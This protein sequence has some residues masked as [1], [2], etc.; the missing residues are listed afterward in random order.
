MKEGESLAL[1]NWALAK[2]T[3]RAGKCGL[4]QLLLGPLRA[5]DLGFH[6]NDCKSWQVVE[7]GIP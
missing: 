2:K 5:I 3:A 1:A 6:K 7:R 4:K